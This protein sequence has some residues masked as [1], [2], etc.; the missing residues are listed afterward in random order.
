MNLKTL[1]FENLCLLAIISRSNKKDDMQ[2]LKITQ[3]AW[4]DAGLAE[5]AYSVETVFEA[6][7]AENPKGS[8]EAFPECKLFEILNPK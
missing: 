7:Q 2:R 4:E 5:S 1:N 3:T 6:D 8:G